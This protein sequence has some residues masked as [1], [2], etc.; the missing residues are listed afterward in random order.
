MIS[1]LDGLV[2][3]L[4][5]RGHG[6][7]PL[8]AVLGLPGGL[9]LELTRLLSA[10]GRRPLLFTLEG[11]K[12]WDTF[13]QGKGS[14]ESCAESREDYWSLGGAGDYAFPA[15]ATGEIARRL[16]EGLHEAAA[17]WDCVVLDLG[18][19]HN[20]GVVQLASACDPLC[21][22]LPGNDLVLAH[23]LSLSRD[24][25]SRSGKIGVYATPSASLEAGEARLLAKLFLQAASK[26]IQVPVHCLHGE[27]V[28]EE[29]AVLVGVPESGVK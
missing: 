29:L 25:L 19:E 8:V 2:K 1:Q 14:L 3:A 10:C 11:G 24:I 17:P 27:Q 4:R 7:R 23:I 18:Q 26:M 20:E 6:R 13:L 5:G 28:V 22:E 21:I 9:A 15:W 12:G 16:L